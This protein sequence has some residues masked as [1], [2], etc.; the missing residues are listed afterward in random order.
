ML[1]QKSYKLALLF[2][3]SSSCRVQGEKSHQ[4]QPIAAT[5]T[6]ADM[7]TIERL[8]S[9]GNSVSLR[10]KRHPVLHICSGGADDAEHDPT[11]KK[12]RKRRKRRRVIHTS[13]DNVSARTMKRNVAVTD[14][15]TKT[16][17]D[18]ETK[19]YLTEKKNQDYN[20]LVKERERK[21]EVFLS[22]KRTTASDKGIKSKSSVKVKALQV[23]SSATTPW[24]ERYL[25]RTKERL[26][27]VPRDF[28]S[29]GFNFARLSEVI[30][31]LYGNDYS[32]FLRSQSNENQFIQ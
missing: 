22:N 1:S 21:D 17:H 15:S 30:Q 2:C 25:A 6:C 32:A 24:V 3:W 16:L 11:K 19:K 10:D 28:L 26:L 31:D 23:R 27:P 13:S 8:G 14:E 12:R 4:H 9:N 29:D 7:S 18:N 5:K 20:P